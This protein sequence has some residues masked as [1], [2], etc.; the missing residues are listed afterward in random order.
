MGDDNATRADV[1]RMHGRVDEL[2]TLVGKVHGDV[3]ALHVACQPCRKLVA[4]HERMLLHG[5][6][7][8]GMATE[9]EIMRR[10]WKKISRAFWA[11][12]V[13]VVSMAV[14]MARETLGW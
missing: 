11:M 4:E 5:N 9:V 2:V 13:A 12:A 1:Q 6:N 10:S 8:S 7:G 3:K 14:A